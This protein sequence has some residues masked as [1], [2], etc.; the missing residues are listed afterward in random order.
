MFELAEHGERVLFLF[1]F[2]YSG[3]KKLRLFLVA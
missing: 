1:F 3:A 2:S